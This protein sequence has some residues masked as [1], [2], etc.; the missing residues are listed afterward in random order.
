MNNSVTVTVFGSVLPRGCA[1]GTLMIGT[2]AK[3]MHA[4]NVRNATLT[5]EIPTYLVAH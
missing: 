5:S 2:G 4:R 1:T 3:N